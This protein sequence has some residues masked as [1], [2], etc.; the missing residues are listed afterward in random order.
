MKLY[1]NTMKAT[2]HNV[3]GIVG[4]CICDAILNSRETSDWSVA[5]VERQQPCAGATGAGQGYIWMAHRQPG[6]GT[7]DLAVRSCELWRGL[8]QRPDLM[9]GLEW[10]VGCCWWRCPW[11]CLQNRS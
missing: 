1:I 8:R 4:L 3:A 7:W 6:A 11:R 9:Q 5:L 10:Q 2:G